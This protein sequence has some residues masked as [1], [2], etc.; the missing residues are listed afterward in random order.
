LPFLDLMA[1]SDV[2]LTKVGY[3]SFVEA[4]AHAIPL[5][6]MDRPDWPETPFLAAWVAEHGNAAVIDEPLLFSSQLESVLT[7]LWRQPRKTAIRA[8]GAMQAA[9]HL[10]AR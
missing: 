7:E 1:S 9:R 2:L 5:L 8:D 10:L 4:A 3:G 6:Y